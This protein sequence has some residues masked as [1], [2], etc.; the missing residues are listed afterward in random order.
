MNRGNQQERPK[1]SIDRVPDNLGWYFAGFVDGEG[2]FNISLRKKADYRQQW[3]PVLSFNV[4]QRDKTIL[5]LMKKHFK[6]GIIK[7]RR[8]GLYSFD[9]TNPKAIQEIIVPFF[10]QYNFLSSSKSKNF[11]IFKKAVELM[12]NKQHLKEEG[13]LKLLKLREILNKGKGR[14]RKYSIND[15]MESSE[16]TRQVP[17]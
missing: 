4:S 14:T 9:V 8:D 12:Y 13:F 3:Q 16:T 2:S 17:T 7:Q 5:V 11:L 10:N 6:C 15:V 1:T